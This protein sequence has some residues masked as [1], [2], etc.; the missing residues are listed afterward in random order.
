MAR[1]LRPGNNMMISLISECSLWPSWWISIFR[2]I[3]E[4]VWSKGSSIISNLEFWVHY[5]LLLGCEQ[6]HLMSFRAQILARLLR[7]AHWMLRL[8]PFGLAYKFLILCMVR[9]A[10][11]VGVS[12]IQYPL[13]SL[14]ICC[15]PAPHGNFQSRPWLKVC[16]RSPARN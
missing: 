9:L 5:F 14:Y 12:K 6:T 4:C 2:Q 8:R 3:V 1:L 13:K 11:G 10:S 15:L 7:V 16:S